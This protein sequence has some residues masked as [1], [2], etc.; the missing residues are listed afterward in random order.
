MITTIKNMSC[1]LKLL[2]IDEPVNGINYILKKNNN[3]QIRTFQKRKSI[4][5][6][7]SISFIATLSLSKWNV[8]I[9]IVSET[10]V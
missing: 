4:L 1:S 2:Q 5:C 9:S 7:Y 8:P 10:V 6:N 3:I